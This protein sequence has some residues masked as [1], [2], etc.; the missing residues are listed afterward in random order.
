MI[1]NLPEMQ[2]TQVQ[3]LHWED[4][5]EKGMATHSNVIVWRIPWTEEPVGYGPWSHKEL[6]TAEQLTQAGHASNLDVHW[7]MN[8][9]R[10]C[11]VYIYT[12]ECYSVMKGGIWVSP[13]EVDEPKAYC[14]EWSKSEIER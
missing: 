11:G 4:I 6:D 13:N 9:C 5:L 3:S 2:E 1:R 8:G 10:D 7:Q 12:M 14:T